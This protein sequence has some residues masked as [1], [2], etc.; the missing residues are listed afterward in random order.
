V[1]EQ[2]RYERLLL[3][4]QTQSRSDGFITDDLQELGKTGNDGINV[5]QSLITNQAVLIV[6]SEERSLTLP[7][8]EQ[9]DVSQG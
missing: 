9:A 5:L 1:S 7:S 3:R 8:D 6:P 4:W 2:D